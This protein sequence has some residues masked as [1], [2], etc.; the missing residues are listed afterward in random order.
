MMVKLKIK[1]IYLLSRDIN[2][3]KILLKVIIKW[4]KINKKKQII[5]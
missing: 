1:P 2:N 3:S 4:I 5:N